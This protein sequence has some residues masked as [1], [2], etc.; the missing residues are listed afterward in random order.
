MRKSII[1]IVYLSV[2]GLIFFSCQNKEQIQFQSYMSSGKE[3]YKSNC[4]GCHGEN[5][6]GLGM[7]APP[8]TDV[9]YLTA[10]KT[11][12]ACIIKNGQQQPININDKV[13]NEKMPAFPEYAP[14]DIAQVM[15]YITNSFGNKQ[16]TYT[17]QQVTMDLKNCEK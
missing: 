16:G 1:A 2:L 13:Y 17:Y 12:L 9:K 10:N 3:L 8:L 14:I 11:N 15:V 7:L 4:Q 6:E 5:G